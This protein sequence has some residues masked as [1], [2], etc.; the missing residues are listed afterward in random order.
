[1]LYGEDVSSD[2]V[3]SIHF[4]YGGPVFRA[5]VLCRFDRAFIAQHKLAHV[6]GVSEEQERMAEERARARSADPSELEG[7]AAAQAAAGDM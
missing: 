3:M 1:M 4:T 5:V 2:T 7:A 6:F